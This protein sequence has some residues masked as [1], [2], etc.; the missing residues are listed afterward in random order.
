[1]NSKKILIGS[2]IGFGLLLLIS[3]KGTTN[4][5]PLSQE[6]K[7]KSLHPSLQPFARNL[8]AKGIQHGIPLIITDA[9]RSIADQN[10]D[11]AKGRTAPGSIVTYAKGGESFHNYGLA[12]DVVPVVNGKATYT[13]D[14]QKIGDLGKSVGLE[15][16]GDF[17]HADRPHFEKKF[18]NTIAMLQQ[19]HAAG[20]L[21]NGFINLTA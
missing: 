11:Y 3:K 20:D 17:P 14:W 15:W 5:K 8:I 1:M 10:K 7:I 18:G 4:T 12:F 6:D 13:Y 21:Q 2:V 16:G 19:K 9:F